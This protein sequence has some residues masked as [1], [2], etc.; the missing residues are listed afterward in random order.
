MRRGSRRG[1][2]I[3]VGS[4][5]GAQRATSPDGSGRISVARMFETRST[6][7]RTDG[8]E[9]IAHDD[10]PGIVVSFRCVDLDGHGVE[11]Y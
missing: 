8:I 11:V 5:V 6:A 1:A 2:R 7:L 9:I 3:V 4:A 10:E